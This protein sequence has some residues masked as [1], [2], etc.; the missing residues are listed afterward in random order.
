MFGMMVRDLRR[1]YPFG[2]S[3]ADGRANGP[4]PV[5]LGLS[6]LGALLVGVLGAAI[7]ASVAVRYLGAVLG[8]LAFLLVAYFVALRPGGLCHR[9]FRHMVY[10]E[11]FGEPA[12]AAVSPAKSAS[13]PQS[14]SRR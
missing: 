11:G 7:L 10:R 14:S 6:L 9:H 5:G 4:H 8:P 2:G 13:V 1:G 12:G 3:T